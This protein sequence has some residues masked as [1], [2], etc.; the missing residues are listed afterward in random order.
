MLYRGG[1]A[2]PGHTE[3]LASLAA[4]EGD[5]PH[6]VMMLVSDALKVVP[7]TI[8]IPLKEVGAALTQQLILATI[9][10]TACDLGRFFG[11]A[12]P[13]L[14]VSGLNPHAGEEGNLGRE[15]IEIIEPAIETAQRKGLDVTGP[16]PADTMF[17]ADARASYDAAI[18]MYH[19]QALVL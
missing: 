17:H 9:E 6:P 3:F 5:A 4:T 16:Y 8:H 2:F 12:R 14:A 15:E 11:I 19:D 10:T 18:C 1:F 13:R 7:V